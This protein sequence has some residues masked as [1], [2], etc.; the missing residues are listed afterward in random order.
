[1]KTVLKF[2]AHDDYLGQND[3]STEWIAVLPNHTDNDATTWLR[4]YAQLNKFRLQMSCP[5]CASPLPYEACVHLL[6]VSSDS[7]QVTPVMRRRS[8]MDGRRAE[9][10]V[11]YI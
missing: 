8:S 11:Y 4:I 9:L 1:M 10:N 7:V 2:F 3:H 5:Y 6:L